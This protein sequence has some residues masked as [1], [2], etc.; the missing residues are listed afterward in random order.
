M[1]K[2]AIT[3]Y[4][5]DALKDS[6][7]LQLYKEEKEYVERH[8]LGNAPIVEVDTHSRFSDAYMERLDKETEKVLKEENAAFLSQP[9][10][11]F[12]TNKNEFLYLESDWFDLISV[13]AVS[14]EMDDV[15]GTYDV[16]LGLK[17]QKKYGPQIKEYLNSSLQGEGVKFDLMFDQQDGLW[18]LNFTLDQVEGF[19]EDMTVG[20]SYQ[21]IYSLLFNLVAAVEEGR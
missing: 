7:E 15:F 2:E 3:K 12:K 19:R 11:Y 20:E 10:A 6:S 14:L 1:L 21:L 13:D 16:M 18:S 4:L 5:S 8:G 9:L 17:L